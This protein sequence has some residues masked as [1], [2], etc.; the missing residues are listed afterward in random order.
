MKVVV[1]I[2]QSSPPLGGGTGEPQ[3]SK[4]GRSV[5]NGEMQIT[6]KGEWGKS[7]REGNEGTRFVYVIARIPELGVKLNDL[8]VQQV[9]DG[10]YQVYTGGLPKLW[11]DRQGKERKTFAVSLRK[12]I[13]QEI[14]K[15]AETAELEPTLGF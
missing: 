5:M 10:S 9:K 15:A 14:G 12:D 6:R 8:C 4:K 3:P 11:K 7:T 1:N 13:Q 2:P